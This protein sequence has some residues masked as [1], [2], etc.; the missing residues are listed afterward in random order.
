MSNSYQSV[1]KTMLYNYD[2]TKPTESSNCS[3]HFQCSTQCLS[4]IFRTHKNRTYNCNTI[5]SM[6]VLRFC[7]RY[8][9]EI[10]HIL[11]D[12]I[13]KLSTGDLIFSM[14]CGSCMETI[15]I[16]RYCRDNNLGIINYIGIDHNSNWA[17][18][19][20]NCCLNTQNIQSRVVYDAV[21]PRGILTNVKVFLLNYCLS[22][23]KNHSNLNN[24]LCNDFSSYLELLPNDSYVI[25]NDQ[26]HGDEWE[27]NFDVW[28]SS[29]DTSK[30]TVTNYFFDP[31]S[32]KPCNPRGS[33]MLHKQLVFSNFGLDPIIENYFQANLPC[34]E[35]GITII[36][37]I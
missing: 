33:R 19:S 16:D 30:Y 8:A 10:Y 20:R 12:K 18:A 6:Y 22:D 29:L 25:I 27:D 36:H 9:S 23:I 14:G 21:N 34:C 11:N 24:F 26:N 32:H 2:S 28:S 15:G 5:I 4:D 1:L 7:N 37:K 17:N 31:G 13:P 35:S 3:E